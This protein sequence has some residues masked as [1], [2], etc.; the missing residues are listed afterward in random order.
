[1]GRPSI[2][3]V[4]YRIRT[5]TS[6]IRDGKLTC[7][8]NSLKSQFRMLISSISWHHSLPR[9]QLYY[10]RTIRSYIFPLP[11]P[12][13]RLWGNTEC[14]MHQVLASSQDR[15]SPAPG[16]SLTSHLSVNLLVL[17]FQLFHNYKSTNE[18]NLSSW[19]WLP[20]DQQGRDQ[21][22]TIQLPTIQLP[23]I[24]SPT[25]Q[26]PTI[27]PPAD[28]PS[29]DQPPSDP[30]PTDQPH[31]YPSPTDQ[32]PTDPLPTDQPPPDQL[33]PDQPPSDQPPSDQPPSDQPPS[34]QWPSDQP[35]SDPPP[36]DQPPPD[37]PPPDQP[38]PNQ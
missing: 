4:T 34:D 31:T 10:H 19:S 28:Q 11:L 25:I 27:Q 7:T 33:P 30:P 16:K 36:S 9:S 38:P 22:P 20:P 23:T 21:L 15:L 32:P 12:M 8:R 6:C 14:S 3:V 24:Q 17:K 1:L 13:P 37:Q 26:L 18:L 35:P 2:D 29:T 5:C